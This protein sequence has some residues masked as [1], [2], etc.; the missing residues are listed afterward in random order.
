MTHIS[1][2]MTTHLYH[3]QVIECDVYVRASLFMIVSMRL[4]WSAQQC[5]VRIYL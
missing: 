3:S 4:F 5:C 2:E 1:F